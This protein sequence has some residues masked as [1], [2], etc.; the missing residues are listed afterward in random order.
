MATTAW[1]SQSPA[2]PLFPDLL[3]SRPERTDQAGKLLIVGGSNQGFASVVRSAELAKQA[4]AGE[5]KV[6][7]PKSVEKHLG[8]SAELLYSDATSS[9]SFSADAVKETK[10]YVDWANGLF[11]AGELSRNAETS[12]FVEQLVAID[13][14]TVLVGDAVDILIGNK[15]LK[16]RSGL[17]GVTNFKQLQ[18]MVK[19]EPLT[20]ALLSQSTLE[21]RVGLA[22][23]LIDKSFYEILV[24]SDEDSYLVVS[25][26]IASLTQSSKSMFEFAVGASVLSMQFPDKIFE[27]VS[28]AVII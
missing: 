14:P 26:Q 21:Q 16:K 22:R 19:A 18:Q 6:L 25:D 4:G 20:S 7:L 13:K 11:V 28:T 8:H 17:V 9:G 23:D 3:W 24:L 2:A 1:K 27:A 5:V 10:S 12:I 15:S